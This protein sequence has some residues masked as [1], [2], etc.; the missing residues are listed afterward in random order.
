MRAIIKRMRPWNFGLIIIGMF[1]YLHMFQESNVGSVIAR[2]PLPPVVL[3]VTAGF[4]LGLATGRVQLPASIVYPVYLASV[5]Q[6][7]PFVFALIYICIYFGYVISPVHP[8]LVVTCEY[9][10][11]TI[12]EQMVRLAAPTAILVG[13]VLAA[14]LYLA[15]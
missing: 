3:A 4:A 13:S 10:K 12:R 14:S 7:S 5:D 2:L 11:I 15:F 1:L 9:F 8:C 6:V